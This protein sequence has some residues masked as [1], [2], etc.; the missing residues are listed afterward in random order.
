M[1][2]INQHLRELRESAQLTQAHMASILGVTQSQVTRYENG[3]ST[4][5]PEVFLRY[6]DYFAVSLDYIYGRVEQPAGARFDYDPE[7]IKKRT[8]QKN[9]M[10]EFVDMCFDPRSPVNGK[11]KDALLKLLEEQR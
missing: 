10:Q 8:E 2:I 1:E 6:A 4:P 9:E 5:S 11:L 3:K 7:T